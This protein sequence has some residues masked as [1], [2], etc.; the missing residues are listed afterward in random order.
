M[1]DRRSRGA[2]I[3]GQGLQGQGQGLQGQG[4]G[5]QEGGQGPGSPGGV[6]GVP[7]TGVWVNSAFIASLPAAHRGLITPEISCYKDQRI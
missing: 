2:L 5:P 3:P 1:V 7:G 6:Q 4:Q